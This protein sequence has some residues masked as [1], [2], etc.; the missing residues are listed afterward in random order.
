MRRPPYQR[1]DQGRFD[2]TMTPM[3]D[4]VFLLLIFFLCTANFQ[5]L[6]ELLPTNFLA[7]GALASDLPLDPELQ[8]LEEIVIRLQAPGDQA[9]WIINERAY[10]LLNEVRRILFTL[11]EVQSE[12]PIVL[13][14]DE[15]VPL[16][17]VIDLYD[18]C[19]LAGFERIQFAARVEG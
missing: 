19:R 11:G 10:D 5:V 2:A 8:E 1:T 18:L 3:I 12:L 14:I 16:G 9:R 7:Q 4:V 13:D 17:D 6:E 15:D